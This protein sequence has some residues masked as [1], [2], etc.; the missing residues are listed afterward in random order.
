M[1]LRSGANQ[2]ERIVDGLAAR[3]IELVPVMVDS[4][5][6]VAGEAQ[7][8]GIATPILIDSDRS[9]S[10]AYEMMGIYGHSDRPSHSFAYIRTERSVG[11]STTRRCSC[12]SISCWPI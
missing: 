12:L 4:P 3:D 7:Q 5:E 10:E 11:S 8:F 1:V 9:V 6:S 2:R